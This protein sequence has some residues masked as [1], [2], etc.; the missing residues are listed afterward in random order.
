MSDRGD[1]R[2]DRVTGRP[3]QPASPLLQIVRGEP[4]PAELA[5]LVV[6]LAAAA[7][8]QPGPRPAPRPPSRWSDP[9]ALVR[10]ALIGAGGWVNSA[11]G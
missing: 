3:G 2:S 9:R 8:V 7:A 4:T 1:H 5:A 11:R 10:V 6:V